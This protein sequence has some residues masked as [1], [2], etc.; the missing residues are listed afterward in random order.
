M[1]EKILGFI[2]T[3]PVAVDTGEND[4]YEAAIKIH[5]RKRIMT[6]G[7]WVDFQKSWLCGTPD[8]LINYEGELI[9]CEIKCKVSKMTIINYINSHYFQVQT[10][11]FLMR[12]SQCL[13]IIYE[14]RKTK[15]NFFLIKKH[16][17]Y[18]RVF[19]KKME[20]TFYSHILTDISFT[21]PLQKKECLI[22]DDRFKKAFLSDVGSLNTNV[23]CSRSKFKRT[24][25]FEHF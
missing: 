13:L 18:E 14:K 22:N 8:G 15:M 20:I 23:K 4:L 17:D 7:L 10:Q 9:P 24:K 5:L 6:T 21:K 25:S 2:D 3:E 12:S 19:L 11:I 16:E 1:N